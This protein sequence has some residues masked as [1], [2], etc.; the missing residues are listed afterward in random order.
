M[1]HKKSTRG[2]SSPQYLSK[3]VSFLFCLF[4]DYREH[5]LVLPII[6]YTSKVEMVG[7][8][9]DCAEAQVTHC[10]QE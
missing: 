6:I 1:Y 10:K 8:E 5:L 9:G 2:F 3:N 7:I 4:I